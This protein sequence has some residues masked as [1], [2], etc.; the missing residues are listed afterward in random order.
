MPSKLFVWW[1]VNVATV[2]SCSLMGS[3]GG[4]TLNLDV[5]YSTPDMYGLCQPGAHT[6]TAT[7]RVNDAKETADGMGDVCHIS[8]QLLRSVHGPG[9]IAFSTAQLKCSRSRSS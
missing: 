8:P 1:Q 4:E 3:P 2:Q 7:A 5:G 6:S 9:L